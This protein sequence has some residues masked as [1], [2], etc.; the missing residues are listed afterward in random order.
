MGK[1][2]RFINRFR[3]KLGIAMTEHMTHSGALAALAILAS[4]GGVAPG[5][6]DIDAELFRLAAK[7]DAAYAEWKEADRLSGGAAYE[8][9]SSLMTA[10]NSSLDAVMECRARSVAGMMAKI[11]IHQEWNPDCAEDAEAAFASLALDL[12]AMNKVTFY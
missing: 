9:E 7:F 5:E 2:Q 3:E 1:R 6:A 11:R 10:I 4:R 8:A 12:K